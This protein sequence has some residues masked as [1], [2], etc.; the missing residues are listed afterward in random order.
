MKDVAFRPFGEMPAIREGKVSL[1]CQGMKISSSLS[2]GKASVHGKKPIK[3]KSGSFSMKDYAAKERSGETKLSLEGDAITIAAIADRRPLRVMER[4]K[5]SANQ[6]SGKGYADIVARFPIGKGADYSQVDWHVLLD[7]QNASSSKA[8]GGR[9]FTDANIVIDATP[10]AAKVVGFA[11][12]DGVKAKLNLIEPIG[13]SGKAKRKREVVAL[14]EEDARKAFGIDLNPAVKGPIKVTIF[15][16]GGLE[17]Y[18]I[19]FK[20]SEISMPWVGWSKGRG[21][22]AEAEF[23]LK[24]QGELF[25]LNDFKLQGAGFYTAG[26]LVMSKSGLIS[27]DIKQLKLNESDSIS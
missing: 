10:T 17:K 4:M 7:L 11:K 21:I 6:F 16:E 3:I 18:K 8:L 22:A 1:K 20:E 26:N 25:K 2:S 15:Q 24:K 23:A 14:M 27:A 5:V 13:K 9:K 19:D 12:I